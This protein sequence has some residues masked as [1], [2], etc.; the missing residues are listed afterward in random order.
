MIDTEW[1][2]LDFRVDLTYSTT[3]KVFS[4]QLS[5]RFFHKTLK[6]GIFRLVPISHR[7]KFANF[8]SSKF[9]YY[10]GNQIHNF[11][12]PCRAISAISFESFGDWNRCWLNRSN[13]LKMSSIL[14]YPFTT[15]C[16]TKMSTRTVSV[17]FQCDLQ[18]I[19][20]YLGYIL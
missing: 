13:I 19:S 2:F 10:I 14:K 8:S 3:E 4:Q 9:E 12:Q 17:H 18:I 16:I 20:F 6:T 11:N 15:L 5:V 7:V 1:I